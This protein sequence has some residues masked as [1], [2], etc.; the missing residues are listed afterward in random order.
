MHRSSESVNA[1]RNPHF[2]AGI[3]KATA[4]SFDRGAYGRVNPSNR[5][6]PTTAWWGATVKADSRRRRWPQASL[7]S[8]CPP[9]QTCIEGRWGWRQELFGVQLSSTRY[10]RAER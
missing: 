4:R 3:S 8:G 7:Y 2:F 9:S 6:W 5:W 10:Q 1:G